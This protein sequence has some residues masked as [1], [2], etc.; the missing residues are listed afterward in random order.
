LYKGKKLSRNKRRH[1]EFASWLNDNSVKYIDISGSA[2]NLIN[3]YSEVDLHVGYRVH[4][5][6][7]M[8]SIKKMS[9]LFSEDGRAKGC[10][11]AISGMVVDGYLGYKTNAMSKVL[12]KLIKTYDRYEANP[13]STK[14]A[15]EMIDYEVK[16]KGQRSKLARQSIDQNFLT[17]KDFLR[18]LP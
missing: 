4:A 18:C 13:F 15:I 8:S 14:E 10:R 7:F 11:S 16:S 2:E 17:M 5:H 1:S 3:Y 12:N 9:L 6:I